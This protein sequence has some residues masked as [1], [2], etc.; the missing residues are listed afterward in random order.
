MKKGLFIVA[1]FLTGLVCMAQKK[2]PDWVLELKKPNPDYKLL[3]EQ[4]ETYWADKKA[5]PTESERKFEEDEFPIQE[6]YGWLRQYIRKYKELMI[7]QPR[8]NPNYHPQLEK[9]S[10]SSVI[11]G[12]WTVAGPRDAIEYMTGN[13]IPWGVGRVNHLAFS[14]THPNVMYALA[15]GG[16]FLSSDTGATWY[17]SGTDFMGYHQFRTVAVDPL[18]DSIIYL[19]TGDYVSLPSEPGVLKS[20]DF[21]STFT[22]LSIDT[23]L[24][25]VI[26]IDPLNTSHIIAG[27]Y[28]GIWTSYDAGASWQ[29]TLSLPNTNMTFDIKFKPGNSDS[30]YAATATEFLISVDGGNTWNQGFNN[31]QFTET[32]GEQLLLAITPAEPDYV[33]IATQQDFGNIYKSTDG[34]NTFTAMKLFTAPSLIGYETT[35]YSYGQGAYDFTFNADPFDPQK[36][37]IGSISL[38]EINDGGVT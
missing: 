24:I 11:M 32:N 1:F 6:Q 27:G 14:S 33:Y 34:G 17:V 26:A 10:G 37:Y 5:Y 25:N 2:L 4:F 30:V 3:Q 8:R 9:Q 22:P 29:K 16:L 12:Q 23:I 15:P 13:G 38:C 7:V 35:L 36:L 28:L 20:T 18:N 31:F 19:G 21:G